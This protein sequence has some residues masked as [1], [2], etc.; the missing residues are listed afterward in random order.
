MPPVCYV[1]GKSCSSKYG[2]CEACLGKIKHISHPRCPK[3]GRRLL[4]KDAV[5][6][7]CNAKESYIEKNWSCCSYEDTMKECIHLFKYRGYLGLVDIFKDVMVNF[8]KANEIRNEIDLI[9]PIPIFSTKKR[10]RTYNHS[11]VL[12]G[13]LSKSLGVAMDEKNLKK[14]KWSRSQSELDKKN[15]LKNVKDTFLVIDKDVFAGKNV[16]LVDDVYTTGAT[17]NECAKMLLEANAGRVLS[18][19]L[20]RGA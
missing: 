1:C 11:E 19:T 5:C 2:L 17:V 6:G 7:E 16:L 15:R 8:I 4:S 13:L 9:V 14:I 12:A 20:A 10:E 18:L 3:C